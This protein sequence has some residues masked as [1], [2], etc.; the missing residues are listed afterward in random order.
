M[1]CVKKNVVAARLLQAVDGLRM[2][3]GNATTAALTTLMS[4]DSEMACLPPKSFET[5]EILLCLQQHRRH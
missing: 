4:V 1:R 5:L 3:D 2:A